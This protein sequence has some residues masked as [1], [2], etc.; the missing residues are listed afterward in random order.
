[1]WMSKS[2]GPGE[3]EVKKRRQAL[4]VDLGTDH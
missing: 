4:V 3:C 1:M 2:N